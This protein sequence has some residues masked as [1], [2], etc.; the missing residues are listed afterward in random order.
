MSKSLLAGLIGSTV[1]FAL[2][3]SSANAAGPGFCGDYA[4]AAVNQVRVALS[5]PRCRGG[6]EGTRWS[7]N[8]RVHYEWCLGAAP[9]AVEIERARRTEHLERCR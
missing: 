1:V 9:S 4:R 5:I 2:S 3:L 6:M 7:A 8:Q